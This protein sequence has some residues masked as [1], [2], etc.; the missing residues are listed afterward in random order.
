MA[1]LG[2]YRFDGKDWCFAVTRGGVALRAFSGPDAEND[3]L[4]ELPNDELVELQTEA[5]THFD[6][7]ALTAE[8][9]D[10]SRP[11]AYDGL[12]IVRPTAG[13]HRSI[14]LFNPDGSTIE[15]KFASMRQA[16]DGVS[17]L[18]SGGYRR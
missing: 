4:C 15:G 9:D 13:P 5:P 10:L 8:L 6:C 14:Y 2:W 16:L 7:L 12:I 1:S 18:S 11:T 17:S 3:A